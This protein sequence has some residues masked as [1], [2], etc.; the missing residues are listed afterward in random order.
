MQCSDC[1]MGCDVVD[2][3]KCGHGT[4]KPYFSTNGGRKRVKVIGV[5]LDKS[6][7]AVDLEE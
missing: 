3:V 6:A 5:H 2:L 1:V 7:L 4:R